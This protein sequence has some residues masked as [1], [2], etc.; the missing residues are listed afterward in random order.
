MEV[1]DKAFSMAKDFLAVSRQGSDGQAVV[2]ANDHSQIIEIMK[3]QQEQQQKF[4]DT[5]FQ[6][7]QG[8]INELKATLER[9]EAVQAVSTEIAQRPKT[10]IEQINEMKEVKDTMR[11]VLGLGEEGEG[12]KQS[13][14]AE[15]APMLIQGLSVLGSVISTGLYNLAVI[16]SGQGQPAQPPGPEMVLSP[17]QQQNL[18]EHGIPVG[19]QP[20]PAPQ[21][22]QYASQN[23]QTRP[24]MEGDDMLGQYHQFLNMIQPSLLKAFQE[25][26]SGDQ[27]A[28]TMIMLGDNGYFGQQL[29][30][31]Q[32][33]AMV[34]ENGKPAI[35]SL[36]KTF[37][38][39]WNVVKLTPQKWE[40]FMDT[41]FRAEDLWREQEGGDGTDSP[42][43]G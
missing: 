10:L 23:Q 32:V 40:D 3:M 15:N 19:G 20:Q 11:E 1:M 41:F 34:K 33:Y 36:I 37:P 6:M 42:A 2:Q 7:Q 30:G 13:W 4:H 12:G 8:Q 14:L 18:R 28:E 24:T 22:Q 16:K 26:E 35:M 21:P 29:N 39:I 17:E 25:G 9:R 43:A 5:L 31:Q 38:G 27:Y